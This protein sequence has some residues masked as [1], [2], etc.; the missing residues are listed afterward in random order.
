MAV[1]VI[2]KDVWYIIP[3]SVV[4]HGKRTAIPLHP[5]NPTGKYEAYK[6]AWD[7]LR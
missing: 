2:P 4:I 7:L 5:S 1:Y 6:E 3:A